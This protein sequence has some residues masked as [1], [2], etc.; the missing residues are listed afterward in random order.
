VFCSQARTWSYSSIAPRRKSFLN[1]LF[2]QVLS[3]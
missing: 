3:P 2:S 1:V